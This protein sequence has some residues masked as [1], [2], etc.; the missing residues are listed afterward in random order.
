M[1]IF[2]PWRIFLTASILIKDFDLDYRNRFA[3]CLASLSSDDEPIQDAFLSFVEQQDDNLSIIM[4]DSKN[5]MR[6]AKPTA[7]T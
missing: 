3:A 5:L 1:S 6:F 7:E 2:L 4:S